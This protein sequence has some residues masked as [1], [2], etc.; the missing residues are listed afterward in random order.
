M[1]IS[2]KRII[3]V[4]IGVALIGIGSTFLRISGMGTDPFGCMN[5]GVSGVIGIGYGTYQLIVNIV[6]LIPLFIFLRKGIGIGT[7]VNMIG[8]G[9]VSDFGVFLLG[10][11]GLTD[12]SIA[13]SLLIRIVFLI[14]ALFIFCMG[15]AIYMECNL[16]IAP[17]DALGEM[18]PMWMKNKIK[19]SAARIITD[20]ICVA[21]GF[22]TGSVVGVATVITAFFT[23]PVVSMFRKLVAPGLNK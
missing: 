12:E 3:L 4:F 22:F 19:F 8:V 16:G 15:V 21:I 1:K 14:V 11:I 17:Y 18:I 23:G 5:I 6:L 20:I 9:Y 10:K 2:I 13:D 7:F